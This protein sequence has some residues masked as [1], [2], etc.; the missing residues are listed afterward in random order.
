MGAVCSVVVSRSTREFNGWS[1]SAIG[2]SMNLGKFELYHFRANLGVDRSP[3][4]PAKLFCPLMNEHR[5]DWSPATNAISFR[6]RPRRSDRLVKWKWES[7]A[8]RI[9]FTICKQ[10]NDNCWKKKNKKMRWICKRFSFPILLKCHVYFKCQHCWIYRVFC[11]PRKI[12]LKMTR[13][14]LKLWEKC[15]YKSRLV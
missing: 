15:S 1:K 12:K 14:R 13:K 11:L 8:S 5:H 6:Y 4:L 2:V 9:E 7:F 10:Q 3:R